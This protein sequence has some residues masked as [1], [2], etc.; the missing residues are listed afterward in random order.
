MRAARVNQAAPQEAS[1]ECLSAAA[2]SLCHGP[3]S[4]AG[5]CMRGRLLDKLLLSLK[6]AKV[7]I[8]EAE[9]SRA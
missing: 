8:V 3:N 2:L 6:C 4:V 5:M 7:K 1:L 9:I